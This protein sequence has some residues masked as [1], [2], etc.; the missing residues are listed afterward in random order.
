MLRVALLLVS[1]YSKSFSLKSSL[2]LPVC[3]CVVLGADHFIGQLHSGPCVRCTE[4]HLTPNFL[5]SIIAVALC[6]HCVLSPAD[7]RSAP[8]LPLWTLIRFVCPFRRIRC[9][10]NCPST[11]FDPPPFQV[12]A[13]LGTHCLT[14]I[15]SC[16]I[17]G[18]VNWCYA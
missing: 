11:S 17:F 5:C 2:I 13:W 10:L 1:V 3:V 8:Q 9:S 14:N 15:I 4:Q 16:I 7:L 18:E 6:V 12:L